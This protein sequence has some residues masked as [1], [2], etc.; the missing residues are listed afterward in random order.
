M[1]NNAMVSCSASQ[2]WH[3]TRGRASQGSPQLA[4]SDGQSAREGRECGGGALYGCPGP[5]GR[6]ANA[7]GPP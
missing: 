7:D 5:G 4:Q 1:A 2:R 6:P 3:R